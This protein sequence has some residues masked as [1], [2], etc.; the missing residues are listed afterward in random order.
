[1]PLFSKWHDFVE[2]LEKQKY[3]GMDFSKFHTIEWTDIEKKNTGMNFSKVQ[4]YNRE[5]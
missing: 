2:E 1:M 4:L 5:I 3:I